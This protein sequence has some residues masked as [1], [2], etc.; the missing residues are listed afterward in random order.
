MLEG[1]CLS[2]RCCLWILWSFESQDC[3][4]CFHLFPDFGCFLWNIYVYFGRV[5]CCIFQFFFLMLFVNL[6]SVV[7]TGI[8]FSLFNPLDVLV[9]ASFP[10]F[11]VSFFA[12]SF[13]YWLRL[14]IVWFCFWWWYLVSW[15]SG[16]N[17]NMWNFVLFAN[18][19]IFCGI[20]W[21]WYFWVCLV[22]TLSWLVFSVS[23]EGV[24]VTFA[25]TYCL[26]ES[27]FILVFY[28]H[29]LL[30]FW[31]VVHWLATELVVDLCWLLCHSL[32]CCY[33]SSVYIP[34]W[35]GHVFHNACKMPNHRQ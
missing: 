4:F 20:F 18:I 14:Q 5:Y 32:F 3:S 17:C 31:F 26:L 11:F 19:F 7:F 15:V 6:C 2:F 22:S 12:A 25:F 23:W 16:L 24:I 13:V 34:Q 28:E 9:L 10:I 30:A 1:L 33:L 35:Y 27:G 29:L 21:F 8:C